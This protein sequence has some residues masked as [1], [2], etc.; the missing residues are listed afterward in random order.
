MNR[1]LFLLA[2]LLLLDCA[3]CIGPVSEAS[4]QED[5]VIPST[6]RDHNFHRSSQPL[7]KHESDVESQ[8][9][10]IG[11]DIDQKSGPSH[12]R[13]RSSFLD[14]EAYYISIANFVLFGIIVICTGK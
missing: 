6:Q 3:L 14:S 4:I 11:A 5:I 1:I 10:Q 8:S 9:I 7:S 13:S 12:P 2:A